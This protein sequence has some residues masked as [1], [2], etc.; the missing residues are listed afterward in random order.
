MEAIMI[1][2]VWV[3]LVTPF[4]DGQVDLASYRRLIEH[5]LARGVSGLLPLGTTGEAPTI[6]E[7]EADALVEATIETV[8]DRVPVFV[9]IGGNAT[10]KVIQTI[11]RLKRFQFPGIIS[12]C[13]YY[14][15]PTQD[16]LLQHFAALSDA[17][18]R[19]ILIYNVPYRTSVN[20]TNDTLLHLAEAEHRRGQGQFGQH[21]AVTRTA[22]EKA[23][24]LLR[25]DWRGR[26][27]F[28]HDV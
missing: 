9:G 10:H 13:P 11:D 27:F 21:C 2:G 1:S 18:H 24:E 17:T 7:E 16:G 26:S 8:A 22:R 6:D 28:L 5:Y 15:R 12:V 14:N 3:P 20:L 4:K 19:Q 23:T 25:A